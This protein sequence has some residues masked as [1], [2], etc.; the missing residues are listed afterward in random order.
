MRLALAL[1]V[2][3]SLA[4][5]CAVGPNFAERFAAGAAAVPQAARPHS[6]QPDPAPAIQHCEGQ[7]EPGTQTFTIR[8][9]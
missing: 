5:G 6:Y 3:T 2:A 8:C 1:A 4:A 9:W 7:G